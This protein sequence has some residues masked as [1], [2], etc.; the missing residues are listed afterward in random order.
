MSDYNEHLISMAGG[1]GDGDVLAAIE[2]RASAAT[3]GPW[4]D[5]G[6]GYVEIAPEFD[7]H[8]FDV[9]PETVAR[10]ELRNEDANFIANARADV[11]YLLALAQDQQNK[12][13]RI[14]ELAHWAGKRGWTIHP[15]E[16]RTAL[17][18]S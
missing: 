5:G 7:L 1:D 9:L 2:A 15:A 8:R 14:I 3:P 4:A 13:D 12:L 16:I 18:A 11:P 6:N 17:D 10:T